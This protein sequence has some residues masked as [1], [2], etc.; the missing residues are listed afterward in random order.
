MGVKLA[1]R[2]YRQLQLPSVDNPTAYIGY[3]VVD[4]G[5]Q[6]A[7]GYTA[8]EELSTAEERVSFPL[9]REVLTGELKGA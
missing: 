6:C 5:P 9:P 2:E 8:V 3:Y 1:D 4:F 7:V